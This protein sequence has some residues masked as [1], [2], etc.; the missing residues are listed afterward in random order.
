MAF[1]HA[2]QFPSLNTPAIAST[3]SEIIR[4]FIPLVVAIALLHA[5]AALALPY[6]SIHISP[7]SWLAL[8]LATCYA[9]GLCCL[10]LVFAPAIGTGLAL[11]GIIVLAGRGGLMLS[12]VTS[13]LGRSFP[14]RDPVLAA[15]DLTLGFEWIAML[16]WFDRYPTLTEIG[17]YAYDSLIYQQV[18]VPFVLILLR[19]YRMAQLLVLVLITSL[20]LTHLI[21][22][23]MPAVSSYPFYEIDPLQHA[24]IRLSQENVFVP[25]MQ[26]LRSGATVD[27]DLPPWFAVTT[28]PSL[29][30]TMA[31]AF[32]W[33]LR[34]APYVR[35]AGLLANALMLAFTPPHGSHY[36]VDVLAGVTLALVA[37]PA[38]QWLMRI[39][40]PQHSSRHGR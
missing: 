30:S 34:A 12:Y 27:L 8:L 9:A 13:S 39:L 35:W 10:R 3:R 14:L 15:I 7:S 23:F 16:A 6:T 25:H 37:I 33:A 17:R 22:L 26:A 1:A 36:L 28:F 32:A 40:A 21:A 20:I 19:Q 4:G 11:F 5:L 2:F 31:V 18:I 29:H 24:H 38:S